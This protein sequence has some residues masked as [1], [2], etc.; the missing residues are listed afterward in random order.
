VTLAALM[1]ARADERAAQQADDASRGASAMP[2][3]IA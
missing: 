3:R 1:V 2:H